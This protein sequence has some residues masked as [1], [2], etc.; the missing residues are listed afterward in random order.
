LGS[1]LARLALAPGLSLPE[2]LDSELPRL[3]RSLVVLVVTP[4]LG[5]GLGAVLSGLRRSGF[6]A[7]V[8]WIQRPGQEADAAGLPPSVPIYPVR[9]DSDLENLGAVGL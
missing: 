7:G 5:A 6:E 9:D 8:V 1:A 2:L 4:N 3:P